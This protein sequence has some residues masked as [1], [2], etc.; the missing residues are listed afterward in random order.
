MALDA[1]LLHLPV[2]I[3]M[4]I[5]ECL[6]SA[7]DIVA[8]QRT[9][10]SLHE[11]LTGGYSN[12]ML[13]N[14]ALRRWSQKKPGAL[15]LL[16]LLNTRQF[17]IPRLLHTIRLAVEEH[18]PEFTK[19]PRL[20][21]KFAKC[22]H[23]VDMFEETYRIELADL[24]T[25]DAVEQELI[26]PV[27][28][29]IFTRYAEIYGKGYPDWSLTVTEQRRVEGALYNL[30]VV[31]QK[32]W[33]K[34]LF[35]SDYS[36]RYALALDNFGKILADD[37]IRR[38]DDFHLVP[39]PDMKG[40]MDDISLVEHLQM[41]SVHDQFMKMLYQA[42]MCLRVRNEGTISFGALWQAWPVHDLFIERLSMVPGME[43][44]IDDYQEEFESR[45]TVSS[46]KAAGKR[47]NLVQLREMSIF[48]HQQEELLDFLGSAPQYG[49]PA[50]ENVDGPK[51]RYRTVEGKVV[52]IRLPGSMGI[53]TSGKI[54]TIQKTLYVPNREDFGGLYTI[55]EHRNLVHRNLFSVFF[56]PFILLFN[57]KPAYQFPITGDRDTSTIHS[58]HEGYPATSR[59]TSFFTP[60]STIATNGILDSTFLNAPFSNHFTDHDTDNTIVHNTLSD[61]LLPFPR[62]D[63]DH[64]FDPFNPHSYD[65]PG[66]DFLEDEILHL[67]KLPHLPETFAELE[68]M[69][70]SFGGDGNSD[71]RCSDL[72][73]PSCPKRLLPFVSNKEDRDPSLPIWIL[74]QEP[75]RAGDSR[76]I[77]PFPNPLGFE[78]E[79]NPAYEADGDF[80]VE[81]LKIALR[82]HDIFGEDDVEELEE[83][84]RRQPAY[85][86]CTRRWSAF[87]FAK[88]DVD[89]GTPD[90]TEAMEVWGLDGKDV[91]ASEQQ[92]EE[93]I[94]HQ[95]EEKIEDWT[96]IEIEEQLVYHRFVR[97]GLSALLRA[98]ETPIV[99]EEGAYVPD[100]PQEMHTWHTFYFY[101][102]MHYF[103]E[104]GCLYMPEQDI[105][106]F[107]YWVESEK[108]VE[109]EA[110][111]GIREKV[112]STLQ[113]GSFW[114]G[115]LDRF[116]LTGEWEVFA[117]L[118]EDMKRRG[119][120]EIYHVHPW[121]AAG[122]V[123]KRS[124]GEDGGSEKKH[125]GQK[126]QEAGDE[127]VNSQSASSGSSKEASPEKQWPRAR[128]V[129]KQGST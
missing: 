76:S 86:I 12:Q 122:T 15:A 13:S 39:D 38:D 44:E 95:G 47:L 19:S 22:N 75:F 126:K 18:T 43:I 97:D 51:A 79:I 89:V 85:R 30:I 10:P 117:P 99:A 96:E 59:I 108:D 34:V 103:K 54:Q 49:W 65:R 110:W 62:V 16:G 24:R 32:H 31:H 33:H 116:P 37:T 88:R 17:C 101:H 120:R 42:P 9:H 70:S 92:V 119:M 28:Q 4:L 45:F 60:E 93:N 48:D 68:T 8:L 67:P 29:T 52:D 77:C 55:W 80:G 53:R 123:E 128:T 107:D 58:V 124:L 23:A 73:E 111:K 121:P 40:F 109:G 91:E 125:H 46:L 105:C 83:V 25:M 61:V 114:K 81:E 35:S 100:I 74:P 63:K 14:I 71:S 90:L 82:K 2:E 21:P 113:P 56:P 84:C 27:L 106:R 11:L 104:G 87:K 72:A 102:E 41:L 127:E 26:Q 112:E 115:D 50:G 78:V 3:R 129:S 94:E 1:T 57:I 20:L 64:A 98:L 66:M 6:D 36:R 7:D 5:I 69:S 118:L